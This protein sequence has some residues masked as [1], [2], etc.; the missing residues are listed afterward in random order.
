MSQ[1]VN[2]LTSAQVTI[3]RFMSLRPTSCSG[4]T[5]Q[6]LEPASDS[7]S[8]SL[9]APPQLALCFSLSEINAKKEIFI[10]KSL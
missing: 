10:D 8:H 2:R 5:V 6:S 1:L 4:L 3:S 7:V 9:S